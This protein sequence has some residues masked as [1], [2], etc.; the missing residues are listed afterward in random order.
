M[1]KNLEPIAR[2]AVFLPN[3]YSGLNLK[4]PETHNIAM[5]IRHILTLKEQQQTSTWT[6]LATYWLA[7]D[8]YNLSPKYTY[9]KNNNNVK[10]LNPKIRFYY[11]QRKKTHTTKIYLNILKHGIKQNVI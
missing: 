2:K 11:Y 1:A 6:Y 3:E 7:K 8:L 5:R 9:L 4:E 10:A